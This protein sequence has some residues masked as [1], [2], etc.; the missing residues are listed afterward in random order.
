MNSRNISRIIKYVKES[1][2]LWRKLDPSLKGRSNADMKQLTMML[3]EECCWWSKRYNPV[4]LFSMTGLPNLT[5][6]DTKYDIGES[7]VLM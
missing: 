2:S 7:D 4:K 6:Q 5:S 1:T 3:Q